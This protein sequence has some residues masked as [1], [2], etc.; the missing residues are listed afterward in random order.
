MTIKRTDRYSAEAY[1]ALSNEYAAYKKNANEYHDKLRDK[2]FHLEEQNERLTAALEQK[3]E[4]SALLDMKVRE[5]T[6]SL[7]SKE[8]A[9]ELKIANAT[10][11]AVEAERSQRACD[12]QRRAYKA[13]SSE[14][15]YP[16]ITLFWCIIGASTLM[17]TM[18]C[19]GIYGAF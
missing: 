8:R 1:A 10:M 6:E 11:A 5:L 2:V 9:A 12:E 7:L 18:V 15:T 17:T 4:G 14:L 13:V 19:G 16:D 3:L